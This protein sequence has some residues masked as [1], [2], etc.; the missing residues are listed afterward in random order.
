MTEKPHEDTTV[1]TIIIDC[2]MFQHVDMVGVKTLQ[3]IMTD[4]D[5]VDIRVVFAN[6]KGKSYN[7]FLIKQVTF[8][9]QKL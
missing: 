6:C 4:Y 3:T 1:Q 5:K 7:Y 2:C 9:M 8:K